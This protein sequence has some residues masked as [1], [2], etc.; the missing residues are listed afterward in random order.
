MTGMKTIAQSLVCV[1]V[2][3]ATAALFLSGPPKYVATGVGVIS[4]I[5]GAVMLANIGRREKI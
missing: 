2:A 4:M 1:A 5:F 3:A